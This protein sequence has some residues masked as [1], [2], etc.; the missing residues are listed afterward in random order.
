[1]TTLTTATVDATEISLVRIRPGR[2]ATI[3][4]DQGAPIT[5]AVGETAQ[6]IRLV[7]V[8]R[9]AAL[10]S[11]EG[12]AQL[13]PLD[14]ERGA[15]PHNGDHITL[16]ADTRGHFTAS[17]AIHGR[18]VEFLVDTGASVTTVSRAEA[19]RIGLAFRHGEATQSVTAN[20]TVHGWR[21]PVDRLRI[22]QITLPKIDVIVIDND[23]P[24]L[25]LLGMNALSHFDMQRQ[26]STLVLQRRP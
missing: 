7:R 15:A 1:L 25:A 4:I 22:G 24:G 21:V 9:N 8:D 26:G 12:R 19:N 6:K 10:V 3:R 16:S 20:G 14:H 2:S 18:P 5:L 17:G 23:L 13:I 11:I